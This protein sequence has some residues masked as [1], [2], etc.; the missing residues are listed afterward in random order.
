MLLTYARPVDGDKI[1]VEFAERITS[2]S[3]NT[4]LQMGNFDDTRF[5]NGNKPRR[6]IGSF[7][8]AGLKKVFGIS[9]EGLKLQIREKANGEKMKVYCI[10]L[11]NPVAGRPIHLN[12]VE[13]KQSEL[14]KYE[15]DENGNV[16]GSK[17]DTWALENV[18]K[19]AKNNGRGLYML[20]DGELIF[21]RV[22]PT[23]AKQVHKFVEH[24]STTNEPEKY[25]IPDVVIQAED[26]E[27]AF[28]GADK[29]VE[30]EY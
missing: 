10:G 29:K 14:V 12:V 3:T 20:A 25:L 8:E 17:W 4:L 16:T 19:A 7:S 24:D 15:K 18:E 22:I 9:L 1:Q 6:G 27:D 21:S 5:Q 30:Q 26:A 11:L 13:R 28:I 23:N 2:E